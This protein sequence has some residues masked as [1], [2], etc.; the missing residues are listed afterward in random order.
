MF[1]KVKHIVYDNPYGKKILESLA[2]RKSS[3]YGHSSKF[4]HYFSQEISS[5]VNPLNVHQFQKEKNSNLNNYANL[6]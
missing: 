6:N 1:H 4:V 2:N 3:K 5:S